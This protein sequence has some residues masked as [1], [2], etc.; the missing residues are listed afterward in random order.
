MLAT[1][2]HIGAVRVSNRKR[3][4]KPHEQTLKEFVCVRVV[5]WIVLEV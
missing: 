4:T 3:S 5:S 2:E 1:G